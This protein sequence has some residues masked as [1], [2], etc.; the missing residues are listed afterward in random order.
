MATSYHVEFHNSLSSHCLV[1]FSS[2]FLLEL[3][4]I[5]IYFSSLLF[6]TVDWKHHYQTEVVT[7]CVHMVCH[8]YIVHLCM[9]TVSKDMLIIQCFCCIKKKEKKRST[10]QVSREDIYPGLQFYFL[11]TASRVYV[12]IMFLISTYLCGV[13][14]DDYYSFLLQRA[15]HIQ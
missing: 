1:S 15:K 12:I 2:H 7:A 13:Q 6:Q 14:I 5:F 11:L 9:C 10:N 3:C 4:K 8:I